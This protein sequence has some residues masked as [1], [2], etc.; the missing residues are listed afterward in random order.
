MIIKL[1]HNLYCRLPILRRKSAGRATGDRRLGHVRA[2]KERQIGRHLLREAARPAGQRPMFH[3]V[4]DALLVY[5]FWQGNSHALRGSLLFDDF[6]L[7]FYR[8]TFLTG[9]F[10]ASIMGR[11]LLMG[12]YWVNF[13]ISR[14]NTYYHHLLNL[15]LHLQTR[16]NSL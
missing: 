8:R 11:P 2:W 9:E 14:L 12:R 6:T 3:F 10:E 5:T 16:E 15:P 1:P 4:V 7:Q 13:Q